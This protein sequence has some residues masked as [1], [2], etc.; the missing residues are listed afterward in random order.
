MNDTTDLANVGG[1]FTNADGVAM[2]A[3]LTIAVYLCL[4]LALGI[5]TA[6]TLRRNDSD[7][8]VGDDDF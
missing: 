5:V 3:I 6:L 4:V 1:Y 7:G 2:K 8:A